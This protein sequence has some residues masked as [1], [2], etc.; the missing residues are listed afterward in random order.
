MIIVRTC[1]IITLSRSRRGWLLLLRPFVY[2]T[3]GLDLLG[4]ERGRPAAGQTICV[5]LPNVERGGF[6]FAGR[7]VTRQSASS[8]DCLVR[9]D[10]ACMR[11]DGVGDTDANKSD[12]FNYG[13]C[14]LIDF[15]ALI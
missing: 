13:R 7:I 5:S 14:W 2:T 10:E 8:N 12:R 4:D 11:V 1:V 3:R 15:C 9:D 6:L